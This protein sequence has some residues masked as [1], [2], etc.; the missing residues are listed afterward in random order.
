MNDLG[1]LLV[2]AKTGDITAYDAIVRRF[3]DMAVAYA[4]ALLC[5]VHLAEDA[6]QE[7]FIEAWRHLPRVYGPASFPGWLRAIVFKQCDRLTRGK[8]IETV[9]LEHAED[10]ASRALDPAERLA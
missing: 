7:A 3:Q 2:H 4:Y 8:R 9:P 6:A 1:L 10:V 5:D